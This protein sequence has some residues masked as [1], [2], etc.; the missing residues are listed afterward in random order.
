LNSVFDD[1]ELGESASWLGDKLSH[2]INSI[3]RSLHLNSSKFSTLSTPLENDQ[4]I[5]NTTDDGYCTFFYILGSATAPTETSSIDCKTEFSRILKIYFNDGH[6]IIDCFSNHSD[7]IESHM[8]KILEGRKQTAKAFGMDIDDSQSA[9]VTMLSKTTTFE[10]KIAVL[11]TP[12]KIP[13][14]FETVKAGNLSD[15]IP[16]SPEAQ[17]L[18]IGEDSVTLNSHRAFVH[19]YQEWLKSEKVNIA[20]EVMYGMN[21]YNKLLSFSDPRF[22]SIDRFDS[23]DISSIKSSTDINIEQYSNLLSK[24]IPNLLNPI[25]P[26]TEKNGVVSVGNRKYMSLSVNS[27]SITPRP[28]SELHRSL[29]EQ[30]IPY[31]HKIITGGNVV[32]SLKTRYQTS[33]FTFGSFGADGQKKFQ[34]AY[35]QIKAYNKN[36]ST[37]F[38]QITFLTWVDGVE[39]IPLLQENISRIF[40]SIRQW[41]GNNTDLTINTDTPLEGYFSCQP[42]FH[43]S[44]AHRIV[45]PTIEALSAIPYS[46]PATP[47]PDYGEVFATSYDHRFLRIDPIKGKNTN[48]TFICGASGRGKTVLLQHLFKSFI[49]RGGQKHLPIRWGAEVGGSSID[50]IEMLKCLNQDISHKFEYLFLQNKEPNELGKQ[51]VFI[52]LFDTPI[53][54]RKPLPHIYNAIISLLVDRLNGEEG[55]LPNAESMLRSC[56]DRAY[57]ASSDRATAKRLKL[58]HINGLKVTLEKH[59]YSFNE[60]RVE[61]GIEFES[62]HIGWDLVEFLL[63]NNEEAMSEKVKSF[64]VPNMNDLI[65]VAKSKQ[66]LDEFSLLSNGTHQG[67]AFLTALKGI[68]ERYPIISYPSNINLNQLN[69]AMFELGDV[70]QKGQKSD[71]Y[72]N[73]FWMGLVVLF[74][75]SLLFTHDELIPD[76]VASISSDLISRDGTTDNKLLESQEITQKLCDIAVENTRVLTQSSKEFAFDELQALIPSGA[77]G[78]DHTGAILKPLTLE[79]RKWD[80]HCLFASQKPEHGKYFNEVASLVLLLGFKDKDSEACIETYKLSQQEVDLYVKTLQLSPSRGTHCYAIFSEIKNNEYPNVFKQQLYIPIPIYDV[81]SYANTRKEREVRRLMLAEYSRNRAMTILVGGLPQCGDSL[82]FSLAEKDLTS[83]G[84]LDNIESDS[85]KAELVAERVFQKL[86][87]NSE[88]HYLDGREAITGM[89]I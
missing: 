6:K 60:K 47:Y 59:G 36:D 13:F 19:A 12:K 14:D 46:R 29:R 78:F 31:Q 72:A 89:R 27:L 51:G 43:K 88:S 61:N 44:L 58:G 68:K 84:V 49:F 66:F 34:K 20:F 74:A 62:T 45:Y 40:N 35:E 15:S 65:S 82:E 55:T 70:I 85:E 50:S 37:I 32:E 21:A 39:N 75:R 77:N 79:A 18:I 67:E 48:V 30:G 69:V 41:G 57:K 87:R 53:G 24:D 25:E 28:F 73:R 80:I 64:C 1:I 8:T 33:K 4:S 81:W 71:D 56:I 76:I 22:L 26:I 9:L 10:N 5:F 11:Y 63:I 17:S 23:S 16:L 86:V 2:L 54:L 7:N 38:L 3:S 83:S 42:Q 52:N